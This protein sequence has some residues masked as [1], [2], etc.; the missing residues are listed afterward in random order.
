MDGDSFAGIPLS[1]MQHEGLDYA[2]LPY[3]FYQ[4]S[5]RVE[6][7]QVDSASHVHT[8]QSTQ[9]IKN[10]PCQFFGAPAG[11]GDKYTR[12]LQSPSQPLFV[13]LSYQVLS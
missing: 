2:G 4:R 13:I 12:L 9:L 7:V 3:A 5:W 1:V 8:A 10:N 11:V 6:V